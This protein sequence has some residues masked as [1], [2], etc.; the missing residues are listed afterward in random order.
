MF[1][2][3]SG[4]PLEQALAPTCPRTQS[5][6][7]WH[8]R[9]ETR[10]DELRQLQYYVDCPHSV[11]Y[12]NSD[13]LLCFYAHQKKTTNTFEIKS[14]LL[15]H[16]DSKQLQQVLS[17]I[18]EVVLG[19]GISQGESVVVVLDYDLVPNDHLIQLIFGGLVLQSQIEKQLLDVPVEQVVQVD[20]EV[21]V[22]ETQVVL[23]FGI[24]E[25]GHMLS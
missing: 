5:T 20:L 15:K 16:S 25:L 2:E 23:F 24:A 6:C 22:Q 10:T 13:T 17:I 19:L 8:I 14:G 11:L 1:S 18:P 12:S 21:K 4:S 7:S 9:S 3:A